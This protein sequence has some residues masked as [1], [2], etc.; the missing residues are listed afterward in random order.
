MAVVPTL[1]P[2]AEGPRAVSIEVLPPPL[3]LDT[4]GV[5]GL[6][7]F[8]AVSVLVFLVVFVLYMRLDM[9]VSQLMKAQREAAETALEESLAELA[10]DRQGVSSL[11]MAD[12]VSVHLHT[13]FY[14]YQLAAL[15]GAMVERGYRFVEANGDETMGVDMLAHDVQQ[16]V[17]KKLLIARSAYIYPRDTD[18]EHERYAISM[19]LNGYGQLLVKEIIDC[20]SV[21]GFTI[22]FFGRNGDPTAINETQIDSAVA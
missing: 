4:L 19:L 11:A 17:A 15:E 20:L 6:V 3:S 9:K 13:V 1:P 10:A 8:C 12:R 16:Y 5:P 21:E 2:L 22:E 18:A 14:Q 7:I